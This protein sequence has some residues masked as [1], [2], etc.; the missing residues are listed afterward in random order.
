MLYWRQILLRKQALNF[1]SALSILSD[2]LRLPYNKFEY[3]S[4]QVS[5]R[6]IE[7]IAK[8][9]AFVWFLWKKSYEQEKNKNQGCILLVFAL[10]TTLSHSV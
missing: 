5:K 1:Y 3:I 6:K 7:G 4:F 2:L 10:F 9:E 8:V